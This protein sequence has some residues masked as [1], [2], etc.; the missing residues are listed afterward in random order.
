MIKAI[1]SRWQDVRDQAEGWVQAGTRLI[2]RWQPFSVG[3]FTGQKGDVTEADGS[4]DIAAG[5]EIQSSTLHR[6]DGLMVENSSDITARDAVDLLWETGAL[7]VLSGGSKSRRTGFNKASQYVEK[8][9]KSWSYISAADLEDLPGWTEEAR[10]ALLRLQDG[11]KPEL[12]L[13]LREELGEGAADLL[14]VRGIGVDKAKTIQ[15]T[16]NIYTLEELLDAAKTGVLLQV[17]GIGPKSI[18]KLKASIEDAIEEQASLKAHRVSTATAQQESAGV[19]G[20][21][22]VSEATNRSR[23]LM[24]FL[25]CPSTHQGGFVQ[26]NAEAVLPPTGRRYPIING[27]IDMVGDG[28]E[29][30]SLAQSLMESRIYP[31]FYEGLFRPVFTRAIIRRSVQDDMALSLEMLKMRPDWAVLDVACGPGNFTR[32]IAHA[33]DP[34]D[35][36]AVGVDV[37]WTML[38]KAAEQKERKGFRNLQFVRGIATHL[39]F[40][41]NCFDAVHSTAAIH[42]FQEPARALQEF[43][44]VLRPGGRLVIGTFL[45]SRFLPLR[46]IQRLGSPLTGMHWFSLGELEDIIVN[47]GFSIT[48]TEINGL[49]ISLAA[50]SLNHLG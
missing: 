7:L 44:R 8:H 19:S 20:S 50:E 2:D 48:R 23:E 36:L 35:G 5:V 11:N 33:L 42:L 9:Q 6:T 46:L 40:Q 21:S 39:P 14:R 28:H 32:A 49:A 43:H 24:E 47:A 15:S 34:K 37:S 1:Q 22:G 38:S 45:Q 41:D 3:V 16:L 13:Q 17:K 25:R 12:Y 18:E 4:T 31:K 10:D 30:P 27:V 29:A 26:E